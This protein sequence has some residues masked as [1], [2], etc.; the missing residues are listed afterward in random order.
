MSNSHQ[1][2]LA[3]K[4]NQSRVKWLVSLAL[5]AVIGG[6]SYQFR[7]VLTLDYLATV[8]GDL[9]TFRDTNPIL[10]YVLAFFLYVA[11]AGLALPGAAGL[12]LAYAWF[13]G[14]WPALILI[15]FASTL[16]ATISFLLSRFLFRD[17][18]LA[19][20]GERVQTINQNLEK[21]GS[22]YLFTLRLIPAFPFFVVNLV[23]G[24]APMKVWQFWWI[25]QIGM[26]PGTVAFVFA[27]ASVPSID[28][29]QAKGAS[30]ILSFEVLVAFAIL[31]VFPFIIRRFML[32]LRPNE[33]K[34]TI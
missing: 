34:K 32:W 3:A 29:L 10:I 17:A 25:S 33:S 26:L 15:S 9:K 14:F 30:G 31:G 1:S 12:S 18:M 6:L 19:R 5:I 13:F 28:E 7:D 11:V 20:F 4:P 23:M 16:G 24:L 2:S 27:G 21:E 22:F 8:E